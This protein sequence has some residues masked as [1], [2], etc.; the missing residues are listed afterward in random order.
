MKILLVDD[1]GDMIE[2]VLPVLTSR[3]DVEVHVAYSG[4]EAIDYAAGWGTVDLLITDVVMKPMDGFTLRKE[5]ESLFP[6]VKTIFTTGYNLEDYSEF[7]RGCQVLTKPFDAAS[8]LVAIGHDFPLPLPVA[9]LESQPLVEPGTQP[10]TT[11]ALQP[12]EMLGD[13]KIVRLLSETS[14]GSIYE[15]VQISMHR[16]VAMKVLAPHLQEDTVVREQFISDARAKA[17]VQHP[18]ILSV[19]EAG[20]SGPFSYYSIEYVDGANLADYHIHC[21]ELDDP[22]AL[23]LIRVAAEGVS[24]LDAHGISYAPLK[25]SSLYVDVTRRP[26]LA[27]PATQSVSHPDPGHEIAS[28]SQIVAQVLPGGRGRTPRCRPCSTGCPFPA[29][30]ASPH[31]ARF[32]RQ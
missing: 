8:L 15:A 11:T 12:G 13:Y 17:G 3:S 1:D 31:G 19:F 30:K 7:T 4:K 21:K 6:G 32:Y 24:Y 28:L 27:N 2:V 10:D 9:E 26:R 23:Q 18:A 5:I 29:A 20:D 14:G 22:L 16:P 25:P